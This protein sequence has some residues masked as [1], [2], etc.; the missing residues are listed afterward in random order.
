[1]KAR[2]KTTG[3]QVV[4]LLESVYTRTVIVPDSFTD[5]GPE[6]E[7]G[8]EYSGSGAEVLWD[9]GEVVGYLDVHGDRVE[10]DDLEL[11]ED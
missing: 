2:S 9:T 8:C 3:K 11:Y 7:P 1:M 5:E 4:A 10:S 6:Q